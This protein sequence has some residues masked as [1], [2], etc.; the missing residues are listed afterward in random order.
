[1]LNQ[2][3]TLMAVTCLAVSAAEVNGKLVTIPASVLEDKIRG[4]LI[5][6]ILG[7]LNGLKHE[8][9]YIDEPGNVTSYVPSLPEGAWTDDDTDIEWIYVLKMQSSKEI[10]LSPQ[11]IADVWRRSINR[12]FWCSHQYLRQMMDLGILPPYTGATEFNPWADFNL[13]GQFVSETWGLISPGMPQT[14]ARIGAH[15]THVSVD[16]DAVQSTQLFASMIATAYLTSDIDRIL[17]AGSAAV[18]PKSIMRRIVADV[19]TWHRQNPSDWRAT[20]KLIKDKYTYYSGH[21]ERDRNG[22]IV[23]A[24]STIAALLYGGGDFVETLRH[25]FNFGWDCDNNAAISGTI[26]G[27][28]KGNQWFQEQG[29]GIK[30][31]FRN[32]SRDNVPEDETITGLGNRMVALMKQVIEEHGGK[33]IQA[34]GEL[35]YQIRTEPPKN[36]ERLGDPKR[37]SAGLKKELLPG[38]EQ[39]VKSSEDKQTLARAAY[40]AICLDAAPELKAKY[41]ERWPLAIAALQSYSKMLQ[42][43]FYQSPIP[44]GEKI[45]QRALAAG[46]QKPEKG[47]IW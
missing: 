24:A 31:R 8:M 19:R 17:D 44:N 28:I 4:G 41:P 32:T 35:A 43:V 9:K 42:V 7:D 2:I 36:V 25:A 18:D 20:R 10:L 37:R 16:L 14:A 40:I 3:T 39:A 47:K 23:N 27:V 1:M 13:S 6:Q 45:R 22:V 26:I 46:V 29:W 12:R 5:G 38:A 34:K 11:A 33:A 15:Y 30:D 21:D